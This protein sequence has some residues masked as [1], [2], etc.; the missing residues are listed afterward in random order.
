[1]ILLDLAGNRP[2]VKP[3]VDGRKGHVQFFGQ[4]LGVE[5]ADVRHLFSEFSGN[6]PNL[7]F[8]LLFFDLA[9]DAK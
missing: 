4:F 8:L 6:H 2:A 3:P 1:M 9:T 7:Y 5:T